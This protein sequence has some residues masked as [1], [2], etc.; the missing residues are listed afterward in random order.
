MAK[1]NNGTKESF[2]DRN[3]WPIFI[4][5]LLIFLITLMLPRG[6]SYKYSDLR[7]GEVY[8]GDEIIAP[9][10]FAINKSE[11]EYKRD[12]KRAEDEVLPVFTRSDSIC[13]Q[14]SA[15]I[16]SFFDSLRVLKN[17]D[18]QP[19]SFTQEITRILQQYNVQHFDETIQF[20]GA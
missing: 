13:N 14:Q 19:T 20:A 11:D 10:T 1:V 15:L 4:L 8:V 5:I 16:S 7:E 18:L 17:R 2:L 9:F 3:I 12:L 6:K